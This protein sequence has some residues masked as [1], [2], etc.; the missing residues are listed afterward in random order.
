MLR[1]DQDGAGMHGWAIPQPKAKK[2]GA[3]NVMTFSDISKDGV[4]DIV[5]GWEDGSIEV[6][7]FD[8]NPDSPQTQVRACEYSAENVC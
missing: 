5:V 2:R 8:M 1:I 4:D 7:G 3:V 6:L